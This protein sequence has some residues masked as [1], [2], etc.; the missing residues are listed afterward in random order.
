MSQ[1]GARGE[2]KAMCAADD[3]ALVK[4]GIYLN[5]GADPNLSRLRPWQASLKFVLYAL[6]KPSVAVPFRAAAMRGLDRLTPGQA[7]ELLAALPRYLAP[8]GREV[9]ARFAAVDV[10]TLTPQEV[11]DWFN[12]VATITPRAAAKGSG[13]PVIHLTHFLEGRTPNE[14]GRGKYRRAVD[15]A[16]AYLREAHSLVVSG[17]PLCDPALV[18]TVPGAGAYPV[19]LPRRSAGG[20]MDAVTITYRA[21]IQGPHPDE[22]VD[23]LREHLPWGEGTE[24]SAVVEVKTVKSAGFFP[25]RRHDRVTVSKEWSFA[26]T[27]DALVVFLRGTDLQGEVTV[28]V[29]RAP[30]AEAKT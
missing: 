1:D 18:A 2:L 12:E 17:Q 29:R 15:V 4:S 28:R 13:L 8:H 3:D 14:V 9:L 25:G 6:D 5:Y 20:R 27:F 7:R 24:V 30:A 10:A 23:A 26:G 11:C 16:R 22:L 21:E 19:V